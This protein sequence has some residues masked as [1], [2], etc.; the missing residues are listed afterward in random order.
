MGLLCNVFANIISV[1]HQLFFVLKR[2]FH[3]QLFNNALRWFFSLNKFCWH[4]MILLP[5]KVALHLG[6][7]NIKCILGCLSYLLDQHVLQILLKG[8]PRNLLP[9]WHLETVLRSLRFLLESHLTSHESMTLHEL[10]SHFVFNILIFET[11]LLTL[12]A[13]VRQQWL[14]LISIE[15]SSGVFMHL[16][17]ENWLLF[18][19]VLKIVLLNIG[20]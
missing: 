12:K 19:S 11:L 5:L 13:C 8:L 1:S 2:L 14:I 10:P 17:H 20:V 3:I 6:H 16:L 15:E 4:V 9:Y 7:F 18:F